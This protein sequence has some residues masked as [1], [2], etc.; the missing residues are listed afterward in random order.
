MMLTYVSN[1]KRVTFRAFEVC[2]VETLMVR[3]DVK[4]IGW[5]ALLESLGSEDAR[6]LVVWNAQREFL[7]MAIGMLPVF[8]PYRLAASI[9]M[10][11]GDFVQVTVPEGWSV[12]LGPPCAALR[13]EP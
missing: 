1:P 10:S 13:R 3:P 7:D 6:V 8:E 11:K 2:A 5:R 9:H 12:E 4:A